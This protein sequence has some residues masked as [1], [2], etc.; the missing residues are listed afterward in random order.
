MTPKQFKATTRTLRYI[1]DTQGACTLTRVEVS[2][3]DNQPA[4]EVS[5]RVIL[6][7]GNAYWRAQGN[8]PRNPRFNN[9]PTRW[10][11]ESKPKNAQCYL[12]T[13]Y[14]KWVKENKED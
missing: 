4:E 2:W 8:D 6:S 11:G 1:N 12:P 7:N 5:K 14:F 3:E 13:D 9:R 10:G